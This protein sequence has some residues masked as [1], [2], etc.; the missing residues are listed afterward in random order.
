MNSIQTITYL[1]LISLFLSI[2]DSIQVGDEDSVDSSRDDERRDYPQELFR[3]AFGKRESRAKSFCGTKVPCNKYCDHSKR[4]DTEGTCALTCAGKD[5]Q[6]S[7]TKT[8][9][10]KGSTFCPGGTVTSH[11]NT[12]KTNGYYDDCATQGF[13]CQANG[14]CCVHFSDPSTSHDFPSSRSYY[15]VTCDD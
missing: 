9:C 2:C 8:T 12:Y 13:K 7:N 6:G 5:P 10:S 3:Q 4:F 14:G 11:H 15:C 1:L